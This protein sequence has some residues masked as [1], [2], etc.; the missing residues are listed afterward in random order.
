MYKLSLTFRIEVTNQ[1]K[2]QREGTP[3]LRQEGFHLALEK[4]R[5]ICYRKDH[6]VNTNGFE[7]LPSYRDLSGN[8]S[9]GTRTPYSRFFLTLTNSIHVHID[10][11]DTKLTKQFF[12]FIIFFNNIIFLYLT[13]LRSLP[14]SSSY[15][16]SHF[17]QNVFIKLMN[18]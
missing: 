17:V 13:Y 14:S 4:H 7:W 2:R 16:L 3:H 10:T 11:I 9:F 15:D 12:S 5:S 1:I 8:E 18:D 6:N